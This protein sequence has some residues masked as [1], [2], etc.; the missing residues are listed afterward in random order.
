MKLKY[1]NILK[2][3]TTPHTTFHYN[4][5]IEKLVGL[6]ISFKLHL[7]DIWPC[8]FQLYHVNNYLLFRVDIYLFKKIFYQRET[9]CENKIC[10]KLL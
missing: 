8:V 10:S 1:R 2:F 5:I 9:K 6:H 7:A 3:C 4:F